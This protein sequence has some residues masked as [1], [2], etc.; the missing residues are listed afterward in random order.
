MLEGDE[1]VYVAQVQPSHTYMRMF[2][3]VG[4]RTLPHAT[5]VGKAILAGR[6]EEEVGELLQRT[7]MPAHTEHTLTR[8]QQFLASLHETRERG[9]ALDEGEQEVGV[10]CVAVT[11]PDAPVPM[12]LSMSGP[13]PRMGDDVVRE[14]VPV[15]RA[16][17]AAIGLEL[18]RSGAESG[19]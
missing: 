11:V 14:A 6:S 4:R 5:A 16:A 3:E 7:G 13:L 2:T 1:I 9:Y 10:R 12:A 18:S 19:A 8:P 17:A 15:L